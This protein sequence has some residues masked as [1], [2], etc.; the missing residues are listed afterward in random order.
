V[1]RKLSTIHKMKIGTVVNQLDADVLGILLPSNRIYLDSKG[2]NS[3]LRSA[4]VFHT[5]VCAKNR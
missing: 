5:Y 2:N 4:V 1:V 3:A